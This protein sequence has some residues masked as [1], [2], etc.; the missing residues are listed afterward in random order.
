MHYNSTHKSLGRPRQTRC[1]RGH[2]LEQVASGRQVCK[3]CRIEQQRERRHR[4]PRKKLGPPRR[5]YCKRGHPFDETNT[6]REPS[7][8]RTCWACKWA[9]D[10]VRTP[11]KIGRYRQTHCKRGHPFDEGNTVVC[12]DGRRRCRTCQCLR[13][14]GRHALERDGTLTI[15]QWEAMKEWQ[16]GRCYYCDVV[17]ELTMDHVTPISR[18]GTHT[19]GNIVG[20][21]LSCN[22]KKGDRQWLLF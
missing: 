11:G 3:V 16:G 18:G 6:R 17:C 5:T 14:Q 7:G 21:C 2:A 10:G 9:R 22:S 13:A 12:R 1:L 8:K 4:Q 15:A 19:A 20:A